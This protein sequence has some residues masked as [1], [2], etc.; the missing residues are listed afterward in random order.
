MAVGA[1]LSA[2]L[3]ALIGIAISLIVTMG[4][5]ALAPHAADS[6]PE[7]TARVA[8]GFWLYA[9]HV[10][11]D[12]GSISLGL[13][14]LGLL[15]FPALL[16]YAGGRRVAR[17]A[18][19]QSLADVTRAVI[20]YALVYGLL[21]AICAGLVRSDV[22]EPNPRTAFVA[23]TVLAV[24]G[25]GLGVLRASNLLGTAVGA[26]PSAVRSMVA[27][28]VAGFAT[29]IVVS[30]VLATVFLAVGFSDVVETFR[31]L[32]AGWAGAPVLVLL[33]IAFVPNLVLWVA[34][35]TIG[36]GFPIGADG[37]VSP[38]SIDYGALPVFPP[39]AALPPQGDPGLWALLALAAPL[40][41]GYAVAAVLHRRHGSLTV[42]QLTLRA[43]AAGAASGVLLGAVCGLASGSL[44]SQALATVGPV[45]W[46]VAL[47][48]GL[49][50]SL[51]AAVVAWELRRRAGTGQGRLIDLRDRV[52]MP[53]I[54]D[55]VK[56]A[57]RPK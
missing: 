25:G 18:M 22:V 42:E 24:A 6:A 16:A 7:D 35:F 47:A 2:A 13:V 38:Q 15:A 57:L 14:P 36:I 9:Q 48:A 43:A 40:L 53:H 41:G 20:P 1:A 12:I 44:G 11:L 8:V 55:R 23:A 39:F 4:S 52:S 56:S 21:A 29:V 32:D 5:W 46:R 17:L 49:E 10:P 37:V 33:S 27:A 34:A 51:V 54:P 3:V 28:A 50:M 19:P 26:V 45:A 31:A 30:G